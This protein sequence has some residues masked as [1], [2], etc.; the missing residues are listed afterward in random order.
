VK[1]SGIPEASV[2]NYFSVATIWNYDIIISK[3][4]DG[5]EGTVEI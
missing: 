4:F 2:M 1:F 5:L 3:D